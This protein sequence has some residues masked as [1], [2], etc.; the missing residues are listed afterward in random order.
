[1]RLGLYDNIEEEPDGSALVSYEEGIRRKKRFIILTTVLILLTIVATLI[2]TNRHMTLSE[3]FNAFIS[4]DTSTLNG[5]IVWLIEMPM[6]V[7]CLIVGAA[8]S[9]SGV[10]MQCI[11]KNPLAS[12]YTLGLSSAA[13]FGA[14]FSIVFLDSGSATSAAININNPYITMICAFA[15][16]M[17]A[18]AVILALTK[19]TN[20]S[21]ETMILAGIAVSAIFSAGLTLMQYFADSSQLSSIV[22]WSFGD[23]NHS[24]WR[25]DIIMFCILTPIFG[26]FFVNRWNLNALN[27]GDDVA[28][29]LGVNADRF[30]IIA[31]VLT[32]FLSAMMVSRFGVIAFIGLIAPHISRMIVGN[33]HRYLIPA[34]VIMGGCILLIANCIAINIMRPMVLPVGLLTSLLGGPMFIWLLIRRSKR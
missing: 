11:L 22:T 25:W 2:A 18:T 9:L 17:V 34:S 20:A 3:V 33:D 27:A 30:R 28:K 1:M 6:I 19:L 5:R 10:V 8:L 12:P 21:S 23:L 24:N 16:S 4:M 13:A 14:A 32:A 26:Y 31:L 29:G 7:I 15:F